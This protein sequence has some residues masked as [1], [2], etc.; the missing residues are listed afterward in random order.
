M[1]LMVLLMELICN[2]ALGIVNGTYGRSGD[3]GAVI[4]TGSN[5]LVD[6][7]IFVNNTAAKNGG[8]VYLDNIKEGECDNTTFSNS[9]FENNSAAVNGGAID[10][11]D[12]ATN[13]KIE[14]SSFVNNSAKANGGA[15]YWFGTNGTIEGSNFTVVVVLLFGLVPTVWLMIVTL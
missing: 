15:V 12:G 5:G 9:R 1:V 7:C 14:D 8:A 11:H 2:R 13:G 3:G 4:W 10:W 6:G